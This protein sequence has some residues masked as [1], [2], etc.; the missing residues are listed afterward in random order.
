MQLVLPARYAESTHHAR[1]AAA[2]STALAAARLAGAAPDAPADDASGEAEWR[3]LQ[4]AWAQAPD[5]AP[6]QAAVAAALADWRAR[7]HALDDGE[8]AAKAMHGAQTRFGRQTVLLCFRF[9]RA[10]LRCRARLCLAGACSQA[11]P[12][13]P[14]TS[15]PVWGE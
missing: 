10:V 15:R 12:A 6:D 7:V 1:W 9:F 5:P 4:A 11:P 14:A 3:A 13:H 8:A 2:L